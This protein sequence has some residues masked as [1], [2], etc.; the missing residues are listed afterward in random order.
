V[1]LRL[2]RMR[3]SP[4][5]AV[6]G[7]AAGCGSVLHTPDG[8]GGGAA[9]VRNGVT[10]PSGTSVPSGDCNGCF[11]E[12]G[13]IACTLIACPVDAGTCTFDATYRY[14]DTGGLVAYEDVATLKPPASYAY[15]RTSRVTDPASSS[16][17]PAMPPC[18]VEDLYSPA[19]VM[20]AIGDTDV[21]KALAM[22]TPPI[23]G[24]DTRPVD[25][26]IFQLLRADGRGF[27]A[28]G[29]C[30]SGGPLPGAACVEVPV[31]ITRLVNVLRALD[32]Q[33]LRDASCA[34]LR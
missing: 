5:V 12:N 31:G 9:C 27:L 23:Y 24:R 26:S 14:G 30:G 15:E 7:L 28:G 22:A 19:D 29:A 13:Q 11:C 4:L 20:R 17:A 10:Y 25:G 2:P 33:Q 34:A 1:L 32:E 16:C 8:G 18:G 3:L 21:Q 6:V